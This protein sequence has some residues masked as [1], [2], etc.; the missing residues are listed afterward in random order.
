ML[1]ILIF[2]FELFPTM[3]THK[4][5]VFVAVNSHSSGVMIV[6]AT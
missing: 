5:P 2:L 4:A 6:V 1:L 3:T